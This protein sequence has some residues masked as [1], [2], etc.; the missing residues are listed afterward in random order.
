MPEPGTTAVLVLLPEADPLLTLADPGMTRPGIPA[1]I[2]LSYPFLPRDQV[3]D[4]VTERI[5]VLLAGTG[6]CEVVLEE[7][8]TAPGFVA[9]DAPSLQPLAH[10]LR[11]A[12][13][14]LVPY[15]GR[16][17]SDP[18]THLT[19]GMGGTEHEA[20]LLADRLGEQL[21]VRGTVREAVLVTLGG[22]G[23]ETLHTIPLC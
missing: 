10:R 6:P 19:V 22:M 5:G 11:G 3:T 14:E 2:A 7:V 9:V 4:T 1:H 23:W 8:T 17:G 18:R 15:G 16:F 21:P 13:P 20:A 12:W